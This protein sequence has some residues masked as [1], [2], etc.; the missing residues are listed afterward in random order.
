VR[1]IPLDL[2]T[3]EIDA[4]WHRDTQHLASHVWL[5]DQLQQAAH[6]SSL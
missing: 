4:L 6:N 5:R 2:H 3:V 1:E